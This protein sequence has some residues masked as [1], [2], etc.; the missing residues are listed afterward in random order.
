MTPLARSALLLSALL[1][2]AP[3]WP[4][5]AA[6]PPVVVSGSVPDEATRAAILARARDVFGADRVVDQLSV[7]AGVAAMPQ[8]TQQ[9]HKLLTPDL[10]RI[11]QGQLRVEGPLVE[12]NGQVDSEEQ[13]STLV[14]GMATRLDNAAYTVRDGLRVGAGAQQALDQA[15]ANRIVEFEPGSAQ[16]TAAGQQVLEALLPVLQQFNTRRIEVVGHTDSDGS[17]ERNLALSQA[18]ADA[19]KDYLVG[20][21]VLATRIQTAG[22]GPDRPVADNRS[23]AGRTRNRRIEF[24]VLA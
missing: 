13:R 23:A 15:L 6:T 18:R 16:L 19:V 12:I 5:A 7:V 8:W 22:A 4:Q 20:R 24:R 11:S 9:I 2:T 10:K 3:A 14:K 21:G 1:S 17:R